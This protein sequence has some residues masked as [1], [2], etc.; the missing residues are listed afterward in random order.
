MGGHMTTKA[1]TV[2]ASGTKQVKDRVQTSGCCQGIK[3]YIKRR[4]C[5]TEELKLLH[6]ADELW[7]VV[8]VDNRATLDLSSSML[9]MKV[10]EGD[11]TW[12]QLTHPWGNKK[13]TIEK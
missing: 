13:E 9:I 1:R 6:T 12:T 10:L 4:V 11:A 5:S 8:N 7:K 2:A 3:N